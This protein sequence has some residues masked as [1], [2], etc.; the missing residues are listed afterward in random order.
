VAHYGAINSLA[1]TLL[2]LTVPGVPDIY[3]GNEMWDLSLVDPDNRRPVDYDLR[4]WLLGEL[5]DWPGERADLARLLTDTKH[6][7]RIKLY[8]THRALTFRR[9]HAALFHNGSYTA[10]TA[11]ADA[12]ENIVAFSRTLGEQEALVAVPRLLAKRLH[13][14]SAAPLGRAAWDDAQLL[15]PAGRARQRYRNIFTGEVVAAIERD[16]AVGLPLAEV[17][18]QFPVALFERVVE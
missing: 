14:A 1:Q 12:N 8:L 2:K 15:L 16:E 3:Q 5:L 9:E 18:A 7:G 13:G 10:L 6:D 17:F 4:A 11:S